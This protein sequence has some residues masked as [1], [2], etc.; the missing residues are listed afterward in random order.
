MKLYLK[1]MA[2]VAILVFVSFVGAVAVPWL[3]NDAGTAGMIA[4]PFVVLSAAAL[5]LYFLNRITKT[6]KSNNDENLS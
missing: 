3:I 6:E 5:S 2:I 1:A 4:L